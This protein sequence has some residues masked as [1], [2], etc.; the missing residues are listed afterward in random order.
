MTMTRE[1]KI[2]VVD[3]DAAIRT[4][5]VL[6]LRSVG[7]DTLTA[8]DGWEALASVIETRPDAI[9]LDVRMPNMD[10]FEVLRQLRKVDET[11]QIPVVML[12]ASIQ[13]EDEA[14]KGG[15][16]FFVKKPYQGRTLVAAVDAAIS[17]N[18]QLDTG[19]MVTRSVSEETRHCQN[20]K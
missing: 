18:S 19:P 11:K 14:I 6:R 5:T 16:R 3:D 10:G 4:A 1:A 13:G 20:R 2:L 8:S 7:Y 9:V 15:A 12:S 17:E